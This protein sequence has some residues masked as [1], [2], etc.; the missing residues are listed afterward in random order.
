MQYQT[1]EFH[2]T[3]HPNNI[4]EIFATEESKGILTLEEIDNNVA[5]LN[6]A[7]NG[8][9]TASLIHMSSSY[10]KKAV[11]KTYSSL[12]FGIIST[13]LIANSYASKLVGNLFLTLIL[14]FNKQQ[15]PT[16]IFTDKEVAVKWLEEQ[17]AKEKLVH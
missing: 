13:A 6:K 1:K 4:I 9:T 16:K 12:D 8:R 11:L 15:V 3:M 17:L 5:A 10:T 7:I 14:R 2:I